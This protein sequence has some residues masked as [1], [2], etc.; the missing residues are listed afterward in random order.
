MPRIHAVEEDAAVVGIE[1]EPIM[2]V[3]AGRAEGGGCDES[4]D[5]G[6]ESF[7]CIVDE[8]KHQGRAVELTELAA[9]VRG[10]D[11]AHHSLQTSA[12]RMRLAGSDGG[13]R[14]RNSLTRSSGSA[15]L[16]ASLEPRAPRRRAGGDGARVW[17]MEEL[18]ERR[19]GTARRSAC[20]GLGRR[21]GCGPASCLSSVG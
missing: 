12:A 18:S 15:M 4:S 14:R 7:P 13:R 10:G 11:E 21:R 3:G 8:A 6:A 5:V 17:S 1:C 9:E 19:K 20:L 16:L 2:V